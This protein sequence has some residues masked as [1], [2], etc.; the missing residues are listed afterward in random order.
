MLF[1][2]V[3]IINENGEQG[4]SGG[5]GSNSIQAGSRKAAARLR[6]KRALVLRRNET[7][8]AHRERERA[9][10]MP[11]ESG[12]LQCLPLFALLAG[13]LGSDSL[14]EHK[15][16]VLF[17]ASSVIIIAVDAKQFQ[18]RLDV[19]IIQFNPIR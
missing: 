4:R 13:C 17:V 16:Y 6:T 1:V 9:A 19:H 15:V 12:L 18:P 11:A 5:G 10:A 7:F 2:N 3:R 8:A 14:R